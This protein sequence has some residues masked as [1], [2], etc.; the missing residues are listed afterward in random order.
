MA[1]QKSLKNK[2]N[3]TDAA[4]E[5]RRNGGQAQTNKSSPDVNKC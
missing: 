3:R 4:N 2:K 1:G 5:V